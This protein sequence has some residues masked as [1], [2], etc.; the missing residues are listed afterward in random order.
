MLPKPTDHNQGQLFLPRLSKLLNPHHSLLLLG[1]LID[2]ER[3]EKEFADYFSEDGA[4]AKPVRLVT[5]IF[6]LQHMSG[7]SDEEVVK[8][9]VENPYWQLFC[10]Y[11]FL[12][13][14]F[15]LHP[16]SLSRWRSRLGKQGM[17]KI[18]RE[19]IRSALAGDVIRPSDMTSVIVDTTVMPKNIAFPTDSRLYYKSLLSLTRFSKRFKIKLRQSY[20][21]LAKRSLRLV[22]RYAHSRKM[23]QARRETRRL[24]TYFGRV[25]REVERHVAHDAELQKIAA[26]WLDDLRKIFEQQ[27]SDSP[28][29]YSV[30]EP[31]VECISKGKAH[32]KYEFGCKVSILVT[33]KQGIVLSSEALHGNP[34]DG[35]TLK[36]AIEDAENNSGANIY[37]LFIDKGYRGHGV[38]NKEVFISGKKKLTSHFKRLLKRRQAIEPMIGHMKSDGKLDRN[39][40]KGR[41]GD[42]FNAILCGIGH[43]IRLILNH[44]FRTAQKA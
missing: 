35:H 39:Y 36:Q 5:G 21:F 9:W 28:K 1:K 3:L 42:C 19:T 20:A 30:H 25:L 38:K 31:Q 4:P 27:R 29:I 2:W 10:G 13:W 23:K 14:K 26:S 17:H 34:F 33:H 22:S 18:L 8:V 41:E 11:D 43:N 44:L 7:L 37:R 6:M 15:P 16:S 40:L 32:K 24:K 12:Q